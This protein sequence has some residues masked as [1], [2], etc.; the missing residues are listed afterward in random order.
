[1]NINRN[2]TALLVVAGLAFTAGRFGSPRGPDARAWAQWQQETPLKM[3][4]YVETANP[5]R[6]HRQLDQL[7]GEWRGE[8]RMWMEP[9][10]PPIESR[11]TV[12]RSW[13]LGGRFLKE[14][15]D[16]E[17]EMG[18]IHRLGFIGFNNMDGQYETVWMDD[19]STAIHLETGTY[20]PDTKIL[21]IRR[22]HRD[23]ATGRVIN[24][25]GKL[26]MSVADRHTYVAYATDA[27]GKTF[28][29]L[30]GVLERKKE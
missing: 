8:F 18:P 21:H 15:L 30:E 26:N 19:T 14:T 6:F 29:A 3:R 7:V 22:N 10:G 17:S 20:H 24:S 2:R 12:T 1:M 9:D 16:A 27:D 13:I 11:G 4:A 25:W 5:S 28:K 23:P